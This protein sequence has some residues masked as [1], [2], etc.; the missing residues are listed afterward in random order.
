MA[1]AIGAPSTE[2]GD[3]GQWLFQPYSRETD[4]FATVQEAIDVQGRM[5]ADALEYK[6]SELGRV[7]YRLRSNLWMVFAIQNL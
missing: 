1:D 7:T 2:S 5:L 3:G 4:Y 6:L